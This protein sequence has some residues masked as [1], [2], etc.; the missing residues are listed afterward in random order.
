M[1][2]R[3][4][5][6][7]LRFGLVASIACALGAFAAC[8]RAGAEV[9]D[10]AIERILAQKSA[11]EVRS[12]FI[13]R[14]KRISRSASKHSGGGQAV[15][16]ASGRLHIPRFIRGP[17]VC[18][19]NAEFLLRANGRRGTNSAWAKSYLQF[20]RVSLAQARPLDVAVCDRGGRSGH[21]QIK[22]TVGWL[23][24]S[25][26]RQAWMRV[27]S[28]CRRLIAVVRPPR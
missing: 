12:S 5:S 28:P 19:V 14:T 15:L 26:S 2:D 18:A 21:V 13:P 24:P 1:I 10:S 7:W 17:L 27:S 25:T 11:K 23:N 3:R 9:A 4:A 22:D 16:P 20:Q 6:Q 8:S